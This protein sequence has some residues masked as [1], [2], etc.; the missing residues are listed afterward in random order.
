MKSEVRSYP[1]NTFVF[2]PQ[3]YGVKVTRV[4]PREICRSALGLFKAGNAKGVTNDC[5]KSAEAMVARCTI[6]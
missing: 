4:L 5:Q 3:V 2:M 1:E 6:K